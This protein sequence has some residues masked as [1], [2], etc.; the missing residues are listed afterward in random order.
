MADISIT[1]A[2]VISSGPSAGATFQYVTLYETMTAGQTAYIQTAGAIPV[3]GKAKC[4]DASAT[5]R[6]FAGIMQTGG[7]AGQYGIMVT[8]DPALV[9]GA[10]TLTK[11]TTYI[12]SGTTAGGIAPDSDNTTGWYKTTLGIATSATTLKFDPLASG[13]AT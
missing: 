8:S 9:L 1:P 7:G 6:A 2:S 3:V 10:A 4:N 11:G 13:V 12:L 5:I